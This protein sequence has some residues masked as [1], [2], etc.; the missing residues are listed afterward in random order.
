MKIVSVLRSSDEYGERQ[1]RFLHDQLVGYDAVCMSDIPLPGIPTIPLRYDWPGWWA[2]MELFDPRG[3]LAREPVLYMDLDTL[4]VGDLT[5]L[6]D[7]V[8]GLS[9]LVMLSDPQHPQYPASGVM[10]IPP[11]VRARTWNLWLRGPTAHMAVAQRPGR[12][13]DQGFIGRVNPAALRWDKV[14]PGAIVNYK[15]EVADY[16]KPGYSHRYSRGYGYVPESAAI[17]CFHAHPRPWDLSE[18]P[19]KPSSS[20]T[21]RVS[22]GSDNCKTPSPEPQ[23]SSTAP[24][25][26]HTPATARR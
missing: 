1:A 26:A 11:R 8:S 14:A 16:G 3:D 19:C 10:Y 13:G 23:R 7:A 20:A 9:Q 24:T 21:I 22:T 17:V 25:K 18:L 2:K 6:M 4:I 15:T 5:P 12:R